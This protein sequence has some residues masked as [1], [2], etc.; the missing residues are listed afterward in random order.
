MLDLPQLSGAK[1]RLLRRYLSGE[2]RTDTVEEALGRRKSPGEP[3]PLSFPQQQVWLHGQMTGDVPFY[4]ETFTI[5]QHG[6][7]DVLVLERCLV[8]IVKRHEIWRTTFDVAAGEPV[9]VVHPAPPGFPLAVI[10]LSNR[11]EA[12]RE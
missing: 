8:E 10:D 3:A 12:K 2:A 5:Y 4:N 11:P 6:P 9:Q 7:L 1:Q